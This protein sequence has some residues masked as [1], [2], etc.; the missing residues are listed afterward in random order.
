MLFHIDFSRATL[1]FPMRALHFSMRALSKVG[2]GL[3]W[4]GERGCGRGVGCDHVS[5]KHRF[6]QRCCSFIQHAAP[7]YLTFLEQDALSQAFCQHAHNTGMFSVFAVYR[8]YCESVFDVS[9]TRC[10]VTCYMPFATL[11]FRILGC[12][13]WALKPETPGVVQK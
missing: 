5:P 6:L 13:P 3:A 2:S 12:R 8:I 1:A 11:G 10:A 7:G 9:A 4:L